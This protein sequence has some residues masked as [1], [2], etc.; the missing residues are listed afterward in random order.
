MRDTSPTHPIIMRPSAS[1]TDMPRTDS[2]LPKPAIAL[3]FRGSAVCASKR[4]SRHLALPFALV[5]VSSLHGCDGGP[6]ENHAHE[7]PAH[8]HPHG[9]SSSEE[10]REGDMDEHEHE[11]IAITH[12]SDTL[13]LFAEHPPAVQGEEVPL[14]AH[15]TFLTDF[16]PVRSGTVTLRLLDGD[17][18]VAEG[19]VTEALRPGIFRPRIIAPAAGTYAATVAVENH[20]SDVEQLSGGSNTVAIIDGFEITVAPDHATLHQAEGAADDAPHQSPE[21][22]P[23]LKE[24][25]WQIP[26]ATAFAEVATLTETV[27]LTAEVGAPPDA[28]A[29]VGSVVTG[30][31]LAPPG[32][33]P[34]PGEPVRTGQLLGTVAPA[35]CA[36]ES[37][38]NA[39]LA[40]VETQSRRARADAAYERAQRLLADQA[41]PVR[42]AQEAEA[43]LH[44]AEAALR[45]ARRRQAIS[46][47]ATRGRGRGAFQI[48]SPIDGVLL[49]A[50]AV[51]GQ[52]V[53]PGDTL[54]RVADLHTLWLK[55][56]IPETIADRI[57]TGNPSDNAVAAFRT[58]RDTPWIPLDS[59]VQGR[60][61]H[62]GRV[63]DRATRTVE[64]LYALDAPPA[65]LRLGALI[66]VAVPTGAPVT[67]VRLPRSAVLAEDGRSLVYVQQHGEAFEERTVT[68]RARAA[69]QVIVE[70]LAEGERVVTEGGALIRLSSRSGGEA[71]QGHVH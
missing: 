21:A 23:F 16:T 40:V 39:A 37:V 48:R 38:A 25:Q 27:F 29:E 42:V 64:L 9:P 71:A 62:L 15:L 14:L 31:L 63:V 30:R 36:P 59:A 5:L 57:H 49:E 50:G 52:S 35:L 19:R 60:V 46:S 6:A 18:V 61:L 28:L 2:A 67:G 1:C 33:L 11:A 13:E 68:I 41:I 65:M 70:G 69:E 44:V 53:E 12:F 56:A 10:E 8:G 54:W 20:P 7:A 26:F 51:R 4:N 22:I 58:G 55:V 66:D 24:Q 43:E 34:R 32:G 3:P 47:V 45:A 17:R